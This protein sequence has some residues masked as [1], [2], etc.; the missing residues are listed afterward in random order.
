[1]LC[2]IAPPI[3]AVKKGLNSKIPDVSP[4]VLALCLWLCHIGHWPGKHTNVFE[5]QQP[6]NCA[7]QH[8][9]RARA[10]MHTHTQAFMPDFAISVNPNKTGFD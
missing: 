2:F 4:S 1:M 8:K 5:K 3:H 7:P 10:C 9:L 6:Q